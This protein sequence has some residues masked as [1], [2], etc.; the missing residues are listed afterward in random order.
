MLSR[1]PPRMPSAMLPRVAAANDDHMCRARSAV[2][3][4]A[5]TDA[6]TRKVV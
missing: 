1:V 2:V 4:M 5:P 6:N 3:S